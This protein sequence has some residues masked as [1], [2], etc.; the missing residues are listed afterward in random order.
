MKRSE[1]TTLSVMARLL[2]LCNSSEIHHNFRY[3]NHGV[4]RRGLSWPVF[5][6]HAH[7]TDKYVRNRAQG[8]ATEEVAGEGDI[9]VR[10]SNG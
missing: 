4:A 8:A 1:A 5:N 2:T 7:A 6:T 3:D 9:G 10:L